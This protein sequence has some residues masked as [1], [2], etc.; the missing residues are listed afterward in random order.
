MSKRYVLA[1]GN[2][3]DGFTAMWIAHLVFGDQDTQYIPCL[4]GNPLPEIGDGAEVFI[5]DFSF[6][7][8]VLEA[9][10]LRCN[11]TVIDHHATA[12]ADLEGAAITRMIFDMKKS[13]A[14]LTWEFFHPDQPAPRLVE[15]I[16]DRDLWGF[17]LLES[18]AVS[19]YVR[20]FAYDFREWDKLNY[21]VSGSSESFEH[22]WR[23]GQDLLK[24]QNQQ[25]TNMV[26]NHFHIHLSDG[27]EGP[28]HLHKVPVANA[29]VFFSEV[30]EALARDPNHERALFTAYYLDR[31]DATGKVVRQ[32]GLRSQNGF[33]VSRVAKYYGG[34]GHKVAAGFVTSTDF[35]GEV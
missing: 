23:T 4:Y 17:K 34:G 11:V 9:L 10:S 16:Q 18:R 35:Y 3:P 21:Q 13:G 5:L 1:H 31:P 32:W 14:M 22:V 28:L 33:D 2:C 7:R 24:F 25:V 20:S 8:T 30:A 29:T 27:Q 26:A 15:Y 6:P 12:Q 19:Q